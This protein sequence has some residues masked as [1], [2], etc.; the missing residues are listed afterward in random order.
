MLEKNPKSFILFGLCV[1]LSSCGGSNKQQP[2]EI[3]IEAQPTE[4]VAPV[5]TATIETPEILPTRTP[6]PFSPAQGGLWTNNSNEFFAAAGLC[7]TCHQKNFDEAGNDVSIGEYWRSTMMANAA[8]DPYYLAVISSN[9][10]SYP[11]YGAAI[12]SKCSNCHMPMAYFSDRFKDGDSLIFNQQ[13][14]LDTRHPNHTLALDGVSCTLCH[15]IQSEGLGEFTS[16]SGEPLID[17]TTAAGA[18]EIYGPYE[19]QQTYQDLMSRTTGFIP[20]RSEHLS[21]SEICAVCHNLNTH[22]VTEDGTFSETWFPEQTPFSEWLNSDFADQSTCQD[23]HMPPAVGEVALTNIG[24]NLFRSPYS[25]HSFV[26]GNVYMLNIL[27]NFGGELGVGAEEENFEAT[28][29]R[30]LE[31][32]ESTSAELNISATSLEGAQLSFDVGIKVLTGHKFPTGFPSRRSWLHVTITDSEGQVIFESGA[33]K[34]NGE[35]IG[36]D[37]DQNPT[38]FEIHYNEITSPDQVQIYETIMQDINGGLTTGLLAASSYRKDNRLLPDGFD[39]NS[40]EDEIKPYGMAINDENFLGGTDTITY[41]I[42]VE[43]HTGPFSV[44]VELLYQ[45]IAYRWA[46]DLS[47]YNSEQTDLFNDYYNTL[48]NQ[49]VIIDI[50]QTEIE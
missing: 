26:G 47:S 39:K 18:R 38:E 24:P 22:F 21:G 45:S 36:N 32:L 8:K 34:N 2:P 19:V 33:V 5:L 11:E 50:Q 27:K 16:F 30:N 49:P 31:Q 37:N 1:L 42:D 43:N 20:Q 7:I 14:Y 48:P 4:Y 44:N 6:R 28:I 29:S 10:I 41:L 3:I 9:I 40:A 13:G 15:Q 46:L 17:P 12:E 35:I 23:C 25:K